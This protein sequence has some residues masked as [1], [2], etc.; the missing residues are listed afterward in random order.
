MRGSSQSENRFHADGWACFVVLEVSRTPSLYLHAF[1]AQARRVVQVVI[2]ILVQQEYGWHSPDLTL[3]RRSWLPAPGNSSR[4]RYLS[5]QDL[6]QATPVRAKS[7]R[8]RQ[9]RGR[10]QIK[11][12]SAC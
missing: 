7:H 4:V 12:F 5:L 9:C 2:Y 6:I 3:I 8:N 11:F 10:C 1:P